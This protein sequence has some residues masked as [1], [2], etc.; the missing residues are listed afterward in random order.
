MRNRANGNEDGFGRVL[1]PILL[2]AATVFIDLL[3][4]GIL[5]PNIPQYVEHATGGDHGRA[6]MIGGWLGASY[7]IPQFLLAPAWGRF[8]D[9]AGRRPVILTSLVG[10]GLAYILFG[11]SDGRLWMLFA[12]RI[13]AGVL[14]SASIG[15]A[16]AYVADV[17]TP[18]NRAKG[19]GILGACFGLGF[20]FGPVIGGSLGSIDLSLPAFTAAAMALTNAALSWKFLP[21]SLSA[22]AREAERTAPSVGFRRL[23]GRVV[24]DPAAPLFAVNFAMVFGFAAIEQVFGYFLMKRGLAVPSN[25][26]ARMAMIMGVVGVVG[27]IVQGGLIGH[28]VAR[29]GESRILRAGLFL[30]V[31]GYIALTVPRGWGIGIFAAS[32]LLSTGRS[33]IGPAASALISRRTKVGQGLV[34][35]ASQSFEALARSVGPVVAGSL[36]DWYGP[37]VPYHFSAVLTVCALGLA[38]AFVPGT[39]TKGVGGEA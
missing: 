30:L 27:I 18:E 17:T 6:A 31:G 33:L 10:V 29:W 13:L 32:A 22:E 7:S 37:T 24:T 14:S 26:P 12:G 36:F 1:R 19:L 39:V 16:F 23:V 9:R 35:S 34:Q 3:G 20:T 5:L 38:F 11:L 21:E 4:F 8:S 2:L 25:Q 28:L 15:V